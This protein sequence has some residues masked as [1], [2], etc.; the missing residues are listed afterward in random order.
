MAGASLAY[1]EHEDGTIT[2]TNTGLMW[3]K[4]SDDRTIHNWNN[5]YT[6]DNAFSAKIATL[7]AGRFAGHRD[8]RLP[9][10]KELQSIVNYELVPGPTVAAA[11]N[12]GCTPG[13]TVTSCSCTQPRA[14]WSSSSYANNPPYAWVVGFSVGD[15]GEGY[16]ASSNFVR[17]V[18]GGP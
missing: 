11:F 10:F 15:D 3:E 8:W 17:A 7:N 6:W 13:C 16:K 18:R 5:V 2:D 9:N 4:L 1:V 14:Y 12:T